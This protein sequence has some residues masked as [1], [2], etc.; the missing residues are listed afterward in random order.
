MSDSSAQDSAST[1]A[2]STR[3]DLFLSFN[4]ADRNTVLQV[5]KLLQQRGVTAFVD[6]ADLT[7]GLPWVPELE[8]ALREARAVAV[9]LGREDLGAWQKRELGVAL[10]R[11]A[12]EEKAGRSF[13][14]IPI[15]LPGADPQRAPGFLQ[16]TTHI[17]LQ[18]G[19]Q[20]PAALDRLVHA[21]RGPARAE[22][23]KES[24]VLCPYRS[25]RAFREED[26][27]LFFGRDAF[28]EQLFEKVHTHK[29][30]AVIGP[31]GSGK[32]SVVQA[33][34]L[35]QLR[36][37]RPPNPLWEFVA[38]TPGKRPFDNMAA[39]MLP[40]WD[41]E[42][43]KTQGLLNMGEL[44]A[45]L[46]EG[47]T[48]LRAMVEL[49]LRGAGNAE[50]L[51]VVVDQFEELFTLLTADKERRQF[52]RTLL[53]LCELPQVSVVLTLRADFYGQV[54]GFNRELSDRVQRGIINLGPMT[55]QELQQ[56]I[57][58]P[59]KVSRL[60][61]E[62]GLV[63]RILDYV[64]EQPGSLPLLEFCL[65]ALWERRKE[66]V[67]GN[68]Q[69]DE[70]GG[71][72]GAINTLADETFRKL[73]PA[74]QAETMR[75]FSRLVRVSAANE[76]GA[77]TRQRVRLASLSATAR[78]VSQ[79]FI[80]ARLLVVDRTLASA[81]PESLPSPHERAAPAKDDAWEETI[82][83]SHEAIIRSWELLRKR[84][85]EDR[86]FLLWRQRL[87]LFMGEWLRAQRGPQLLLRDPQI[88]EAVRWWRER[89]QDLNPDE[90]EFIRL[91][92]QQAQ[93]A[94]RG[95]RLVGR[96]ALAAVAVLL[97]GLI[98]GWGW[99]RTAT[100]QSQR[101]ARLAPVSE[102]LGREYFSGYDNPQKVSEWI[103]AL[104]LLGMADEAL[105]AAREFK[106]DDKRGK[107]FLII[108][109]NL[110]A[111][112]HPEAGAALRGAM[113]LDYPLDPD[114]RLIT[115]LAE[116]MAK[117]DHVGLLLPSLQTHKDPGSRALMLSAAAEGL[118]RAGHVAHAQAFS[119]ARDSAAQV[120]EPASQ[121][122]LLLRLA[123]NASQ[124]GILD[125][126]AAALSQVRAILGSDDR[127]T[128]PVARLL[129]IAAELAELGETDVALEMLRQVV[130]RMRLDDTDAFSDAVKALAQAGRQKEVLALI[131]D[132]IPMASVSTRTMLRVAVVGICRAE[133][134]GCLSLA[135][136]ELD[137][138]R[139]RSVLLESSEA[140]VRRGEVDEAQRIL[141]A[142]VARV[143]RLAP[144]DLSGELRLYGV[145]SDTQLEQLLEQLF[146]AGAH[147]KAI[148]L[149]L[150]T[151]QV[152][153]SDDN[154]QRL[155]FDVISRLVQRGLVP[156]AR[157]FAQKSGKKNLLLGTLALA[158][159]FQLQKGD[160]QSAEVLLA[161]IETSISAPQGPAFPWDTWT[162]RNNSWFLGA[163]DALVKAGMPQQARA[164]V[165]RLPQGKEEAN[166]RLLVKLEEAGRY[167]DATQVAAEIKDRA[168]R[169]LAYADAAIL[170]A[171]GDR[172]E[173]AQ[174][175][176]GLIDYRTERSKALAAL[177]R[178]YGRQGNLPKAVETAEGCIS[179]VDRLSA[180]TYLLGTIVKKE[181]PHLEA[182]LMD[183][184][185]L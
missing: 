82:E 58:E 59:A 161:D 62:P 111:I 66:G 42:P 131:E 176:L 97:L 68:A 30:V 133:P 143:M 34:L 179:P 126:A 129:R 11:Q 106:E 94:T 107:A 9:F 140:L 169:S 171:D 177:A 112:R 47:K 78:S 128:W 20:D 74:D 165:K 71:V 36:R 164:L 175:L 124:A 142:L 103:R 139:V 134:R 69:Y 10:G 43:N 12:E 145:Y 99:T 86:Q 79:R 92:E 163:I 81:R 6:Q 49:A 117:Q 39:T 37:E 180:F 26:S 93:R 22:D 114:F 110:V 44:V 40:L 137:N 168:S 57:E 157:S 48:P 170:L 28:T 54:I 8:R 15:L 56:V 35:P 89:A 172:G 17:D 33:G 23:L 32:S 87:N 130:G 63:K 174:E 51:L 167:E 50:R 181:S 149:V 150:Y 31:S 91:S 70:I 141:D 19:I 109:R 45:Q 119:L 55:P 158:L 147:E 61:F 3:R 53:E 73:T 185:P 75:L 144:Y 153:P 96:A 159:T 13:P 156:Q 95:Q 25:L 2:E 4:S 125:E 88:Q 155:E 135:D 118:G 5:L 67:L 115:E 27:P 29:L 21:I 116:A 182:L 178:W 122:A 102:V 162:S 121:A 151:G 123:R 98:G 101:I 104:T 83:V 138:H 16:T 108:A 154:Q 80:E 38:F 173:R 160:T 146:N 14:V 1:N 84:L 100:Y 152:L 64:Q 136:G 148:A 76:E 77:D 60:R 46:R 120:S 113:E 166:A 127:R 65:T 52:V 90:Q 7:P 105:R 184:K 72:A 41:R 24:S 183:S 18:Q 132:N 85:D